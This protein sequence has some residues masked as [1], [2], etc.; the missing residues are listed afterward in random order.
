MKDRGPNGI[1]ASQV[2]KKGTEKHISFLELVRVFGE[3]RKRADGADA[4]EEG[5]KA[6]EPKEAI[7]IAKQFIVRLEADLSEERERS[8]RYERENEELRRRS[9][10]LVTRLLPSAT[11]QGFFR[12]LFRR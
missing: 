3:P 1:Q 10:E 9:D 4:R 7:E 5:R 2:T 6:D 12:N 11:K 8:K